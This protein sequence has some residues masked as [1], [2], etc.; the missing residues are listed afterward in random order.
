MKNININQISDSINMLPNQMEQILNEHYSVKIPR[1]FKNITQIVVN[2]MGASN[3]GAGIIKSVFSK[4]IKFPISITPGYSVPA[5]VNKNTLYIISSYSGNTEEPLIAY[6]QAKKQ[7][8]KILA[9]T[10]NTDKNKLKSIMKKNN[11]PGIIFKTNY[12]PSLQPRLGLG[13]SIFSILILLAKSGLLQISKKE[14]QN[15]IANLKTLN[16]SSKTISKKIA[17]KMIKKQPIIVGAEFLF[18]NLRILRNQLCETSK[19]FAS[20]LSLPEL[21][22][23]AMEG[24]TNPPENKKNLIFLFLDSNLYYPRIKKRN[25]ITKKIVEKNNIKIISYKMKS[26]TE[27]NQSLEALQLGSWITFYLAIKN[28][29][30]PAEIPWVNLF[31]KKLK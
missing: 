27:L 29:V 22:H 26:N 11:I 19:N 12:N 17:L 16:N 3:L 5:H 18:G 23:Y 20:Y 7:K 9:I 10:S 31:K 6:N 14:M 25:E 28:K 4:K 13:Y 15:T 8:A 2:G 24:L 1:N 30:N 21:N